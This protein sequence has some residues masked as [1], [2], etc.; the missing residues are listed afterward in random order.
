MGASSMRT[1]RPN[2]STKAMAP[3]TTPAMA[4]SVVL[5]SVESPEL[6]ASEDKEE[7]ALIEGK[8]MF[9]LSTRL[10]ITPKLGL[11]RPVTASQPGAAE[12]K[13]GQQFTS[14]SEW[15]A[16]QA[17]NNERKRNE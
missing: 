13:L 5:W 1:N 2:P 10:E 6:E 8:G 4:V 9:W 12:K 3:I 17:Y 16:P 7:L 11:P 14:L 15:P